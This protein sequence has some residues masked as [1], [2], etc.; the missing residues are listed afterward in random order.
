[1]TFVQHSK[2]SSGQTEHVSFRV[3]DTFNSLWMPW[4]PDNQALMQEY[5]AHA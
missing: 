4:T 3:N 2:T 5:L 1:M